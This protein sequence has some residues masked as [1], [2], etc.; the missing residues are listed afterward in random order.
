MQGKRSG[1][2]NNTLPVADVHPHPSTVSS[3]DYLVRRPSTTTKLL[4]HTQHTILFLN[5]NKIVFVHLLG[6]LCS[7]WFAV[8][9]PRV[10][11]EYD[12]WSSC[13]GTYILYIV[14]PSPTPLILS[15]FC[16]HLQLTWGTEC[17]KYPLLLVLLLCFVA[18]RSIL[19]L[20]VA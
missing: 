4:P 16:K 10:F 11:V 18:A 3:P 8:E 7:V 1:S 12:W 2:H 15:A 6:C 5:Q 14:C 20:M 13:M 19:S 9:W 17:Q